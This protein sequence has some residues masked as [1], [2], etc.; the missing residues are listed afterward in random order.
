MVIPYG[1]HLTGSTSQYSFIALT[2]KAIVLRRTYFTDIFP[3]RSNLQNQTCV[4]PVASA[5]VC[6]HNRAVLARS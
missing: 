4:S 1:F 3:V 6:L 2:D 5:C